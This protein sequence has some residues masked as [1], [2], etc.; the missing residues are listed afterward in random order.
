MF[1]KMVCET[2]R[3]E[4]GSCITHLQNKKL[5]S[6]NVRSSFLVR[7]RL[8]EKKPL[9]QA[10]LAALHALANRDLP[11]GSWPQYDYGP[12][13]QILEPEYRRTEGLHFT[14]LINHGSPD[15]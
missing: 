12:L 2:N 3:H 8:S 15:P 5:C 1:V 10:E 9:P 14:K 6:A 13:L 7:R 4:A 11:L